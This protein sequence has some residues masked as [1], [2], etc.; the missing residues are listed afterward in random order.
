MQRPLEA[1]GAGCGHFGAYLSNDG[2]HVFDGQDVNSKDDGHFQRRTKFNTKVFS[3]RTIF[4]SQEI[5][6]AEFNDS[7]TVADVQH[8]R[9][10]RPGY[11]LFLFLYTL[12]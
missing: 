12:F 1:P 5:G 10:E 2:L 3:K 6:H 7:A 11:Y 4:A 9:V 8:L